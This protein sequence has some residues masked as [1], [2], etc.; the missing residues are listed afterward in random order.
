MKAPMAMA[1]ALVLLLGLSRMPVVAASPES[2]EYREEGAPA[3]PVASDPERTGLPAEPAAL[4]S[5]ALGNSNLDSA[6]A[7]SAARAASGPGIPSIG[8]PVLGPDSATGDTAG[9]PSLALMPTAANPHGRPG[10]EDRLAVTEALRLGAEQSRRYRVLSPEE[11]ALPYGRLSSVP[12]DCFTQACALIT[13]RKLGVDLLLLS[14][15]KHGLPASDAPG[16]RPAASLSLALVETRTGRVRKAVWTRACPGNASAIAFAQQAVWH[17]LL[18]GPPGAASRGGPDS[19]SAAADGADSGAA[20]VPAA[21]ALASAPKAGSCLVVAESAVDSGSWPDIPWLN[22]SDTVDNRKHWLAAGSGLALAGLG[23]AWAQGQLLQEDGNGAAGPARPLRSG[24]GASSFQRGFFAVPN[25]GA[26][27]A[28]MGGAGIAH[29]DDALAV[30]MNPAG[31]AD[32]KRENVLAAKRNLPG[33]SASLFLAY[34]GPLSHGWFQGLG[35][36]HEGDDLANETTV[37]AVLAGDWGAITRGLAGLKTGGGLKFYLAK[38]G[39]GGTGI[40]RST[41]HSFGMGLDLGLRLR[42]SPDI[43]GALSVRDAFGFLRHANTFT[44]R[45]YWETLPPEYRVGAAYRVSSDILLIIDGQKGMIADQVDHVRF[46]GEKT[47]FGILALRAGMHQVF[48][49]QTVRKVALG[50]GLDS[51]AIAKSRRAG[52]VAVNYAYDF[53]LG[54]DESLGG[55]QQFSLDV[56]W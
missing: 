22:P 47:V 31:V 49:R 39:E 23:L 9:R 28:A 18:P 4:D 40:D 13:A 5:A 26:K 15:L 55:G 41:G 36:Q 42:L 11:T 21:A 34:A 48:G 46:G 32:A 44:D 19:L 52:H 16:S 10:R 6:A 25:L 1:M 54:E 30:I 3:L 12:K 20:D 51:E 2:E 50:F 8:N 56:S 53:G 27:Y 45:T 7:D 17:L 14:E 38:V 43:T 24:S 35:I 37:E 33:G 29:V